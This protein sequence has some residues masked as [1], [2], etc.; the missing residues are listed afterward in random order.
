LSNLVGL[1]PKAANLN[2]KQVRYRQ[3]QRSSMDRAEVFRGWRLDLDDTIG[4]RKRTE[5]Q[6]CQIVSWLRMFSNGH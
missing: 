3:F 2:T 1:K 4:Q 5:I 6:V